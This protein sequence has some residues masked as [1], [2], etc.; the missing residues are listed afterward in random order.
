MKSLAPVMFLAC[1]LAKSNAGAE[2]SS[3]Q[4][5]ARFHEG[6]EA[7]KSG[8]YVVA[9]AKFEESEKLDPSPGTV[10]NLAVCE[11]RQ[12]HLV[13]A[14]HLVDLFLA[15][16][17]PEDDRRPAAQQF[18]RDLDARI[19][20]LDI[21]IEP[22]WVHD[23]QVVVDDHEVSLVPGRALA[24]DPG[25]HR[26]SVSAPGYVEQ[27]ESVVLSEGQARAARFS[28]RPAVVA[29]A[30]SE[31]AAPPVA[32]RALPPLFYVALGTGIAAT[33][34]AIE[35]GLIVLSERAKIADHCVDKRCDEAGLAAG[36][37]G[38]VYA[39]INTASIPFALAGASLAAYLLVSRGDQARP[40]LG[41]R[42]SVALEQTALVFEMSAP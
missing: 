14:R 6:R 28:L 20:H 16:A 4:A 27:T 38:N 24:V 15:R 8:D 21:A 2:Q 25:T 26:V 11:E 3:D 33:L 7:M 19:S 17:V 40:Q 18:R 12:A 37:R 5:S 32:K 13:H 36:R 23:A 9:C 41:V 35:S 22:G 30:L 31:A 29:P 1:L 10:L 34:T 39:N 42:V